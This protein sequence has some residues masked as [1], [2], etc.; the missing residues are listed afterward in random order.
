VG[1]P[2]VDQGEIDQEIV[3]RFSS[4]PVTRDSIQKHRRQSV[5]EVQTTP[6]S[7]CAFPPDNISSN[8]GFDAPKPQMD[9]IDLNSA[10]DEYAQ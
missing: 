5:V 1:S 8:M 3:R 10:A 7:N 4:E 2:R 9:L 6:Y